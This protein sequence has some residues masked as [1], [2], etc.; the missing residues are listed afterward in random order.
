MPGCRFSVSPLVRL[1]ILLYRVTAVVGMAVVLCGMLG[2]S[3]CVLL[4]PEKFGTF[5]VVQRVGRAWL[6]TAAKGFAAGGAYARNGWPR[7][8]L[9]PSP[10]VQPSHSPTPCT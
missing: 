1:P 4:A 6:S 10:P 3:V 8:T 7:V 5:C 9:V 2:A